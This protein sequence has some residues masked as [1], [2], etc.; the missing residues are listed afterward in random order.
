MKD[1]VSEFYQRSSL[2]VPAHLPFGL[3]PEIRGE[4]QW[5]VSFLP[6]VCCFVPS[7]FH[8]EIEELMD[9]LLQCLVVN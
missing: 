7:F 5:E 8:T 1:L 4:S 2:G 9:L 3:T 6:V